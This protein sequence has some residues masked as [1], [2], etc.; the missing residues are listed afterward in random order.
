ML[1]FALPHWVNDF[2][3]NGKDDGCTDNATIAKQ[4]WQIF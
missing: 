1:T 3:V 2:E 4:A